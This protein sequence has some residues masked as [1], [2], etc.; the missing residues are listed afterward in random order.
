MLK[1]ASLIRL[2]RKCY[3]CKLLFLSKLPRLLE[4]FGRI[5]RNL[6]SVSVNLRNLRILFEVGLALFEESPAPFLRF[7][8]KIVEHGG[9]AGKLLDACLSVEFGIQSGLD[10]AEG[11]GREI[12]LFFFEE[13]LFGQCA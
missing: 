10:H 7:V 4:R 9:I 3:P 6:L 2:K 11:D 1:R 12:Q 5:C 13:C 8:E